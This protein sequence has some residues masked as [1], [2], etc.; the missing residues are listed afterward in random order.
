MEP[1]RKA[2]E[3][4]VG[5]RQNDHAA[6]DV[7][8]GVHAHRETDYAKQIGEMQLAYGETNA[9]L[10]KQAEAA[11]KLSK[12]FAEWKAVAESKLESS[13]GQMRRVTAAVERVLIKV[14][15]LASRAEE[16]ERS[17][18]RQQAEIVEL[19]EIVNRLARELDTKSSAAQPLPVLANG[20]EDAHVQAETRVE[21]RQEEKAPAEHMVGP[22]FAL[23]KVDQPFLTKEG[24]QRI[25]FELAE[26]LNVMETLAS[27]L[28][29]RR[30]KALGESLEKFPLERLPELFDALASEV[31]DDQR[32]IEFRQRLD[33][34]A[35]PESLATLR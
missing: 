31:A 29:L 28:L 13:D 20:S 2:L 26:A 12:N 11:D 18:S 27:L 32:R 21:A 35:S 19:R 23:P 4:P 24:T 22:K 34:R 3:V 8:D 16:Q 1:D 17:S 9:A 30:V 6:T 14:Q 5:A 25:T 15:E 7:A 10:A 33:R